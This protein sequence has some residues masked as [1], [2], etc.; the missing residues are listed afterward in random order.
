MRRESLPNRTMCDFEWSRLRQNWT[1]QRTNIFNDREM[2]P[3]FLLDLLLYIMKMP[4]WPK[5]DD[6]EFFR[7]HDR[8]KFCKHLVKISGLS[9]YLNIWADHFIFS[10]IRAPM[11]A[12]SI[13]NLFNCILYRSKK[14]FIKLLK[15]PS[16]RFILRQRNWCKTVIFCC[17]GNC[18]DEIF[19]SF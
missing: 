4:K 1:E 12:I 16:S 18:C 7:N 8:I 9:F 10:T 14:P 5:M 11:E 17:W 6:H 3:S 15:S 13:N 19:I 2:S